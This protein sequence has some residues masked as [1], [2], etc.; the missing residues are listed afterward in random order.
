MK[1]YLA[2]P[3][4]TP[5]EREFNLEITKIIEAN[6]NHEVFLPQ[7]D[8]YLLDDEIKFGNDINKVKNEIFQN[9]TTAMDNSDVIFAV[10]NGRVIDEGVAFEM[11][12]GFA[13]G[14]TCWAYKND[15][16]QLLE[17][18]DNPMIEG[19]IGMR[20]NSIEEIKEHFLT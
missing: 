20:F 7:R 15:C 3:L 5:H 12:Y 18:G 14:L 10:L 16:R 11:G 13:K 4:F 6:P 2:A 9:D 8:G 1:F 19:A 17:S